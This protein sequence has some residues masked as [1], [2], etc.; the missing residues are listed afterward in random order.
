MRLSPT[1]EEFCRFAATHRVV[2]VWRELLFDV[3]TAVTAYAR[4]ARPPFGFLLE[5]VVGGEQWARYTFLGTRPSAVW[6]LR[7]GHV[8]WW[9][10][11]RGWVS[12]DTDDPLGDLDARL[13]ARTAPQIPDLPRLWG[14]A[15][16]YFA[17]DVV[18]LVERPST[19]CWVAPGPLR[20]W[21]SSL[22]SPWRT[23]PPGTKRAADGSTD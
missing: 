21:R 6:R 1:F 20:R 12:V 8:E 22:A 19:T 10:P 11:E 13:R 18:R 7:G 9:R 5:S 14:G 4:V 2:P 16:G 3:D 15:V 23:W 17:Y